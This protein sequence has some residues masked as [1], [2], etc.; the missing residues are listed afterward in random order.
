MEE[1]FSSLNEPLLA[2]PAVPRNFLTR[3]FGPGAV[4]PLFELPHTGQELSFALIGGYVY[5]GPI[6]ELQ[7]MYFFGDGDS[8]SGRVWTLRYDGTTPTNG[9]NFTDFARWSD[10]NPATADLLVPDAGSLFIVSSFGQDSQGN[11][12][13]IDLTNGELFEIT[14]GGDFGRVRG[15][16][17]IP[18]GQTTALIMVPIVGDRLV[19]GDETF[20]VTLSNP[21]GD[22]IDRGQGVGTILDGDAPPASPRVKSVVGNDGAAQRSL[23]MSV[24]MTFMGNP[25]NAFHGTGPLG[26]VG[27][28]MAL[29]QDATGTRTVVTLTFTG[30]GIVNGSLADGRYTLTIDGD[31]IVDASGA[32]VGGDGDGT[33]G[34]TAQAALFRLF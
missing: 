26:P 32:P 10:N 27:L 13:I 4:D 2:H 20:Y 1:D 31:S 17:T 3:L 9:T 19:E 11:L 7:G 21:V 5:R 22:T 14:E 34:G 25:A 33:A 12:L 23:V 30:S 8:R 6:A 29:T 16:V 24:M 18:A 28:N 15:T